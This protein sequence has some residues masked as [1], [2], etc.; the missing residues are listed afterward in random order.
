MENSLLKPKPKFHF[1][2]ATTQKV[3]TAPQGGSHVSGFDFGGAK[4]AAATAQGKPCPKCGRP[5][6]TGAVS[7]YVCVYDGTTI[8]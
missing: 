5:M 3:D 8:G 2:P 6:A 7:K 4:P 1:G